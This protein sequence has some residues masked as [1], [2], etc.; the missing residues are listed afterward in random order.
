MKCRHCLA[1]VE[2][3]FLDLGTAPPSNAYLTLEEAR[4]PESWLPLRLLVCDRCWLVQTEDFAGREA[5]F[6]REYAYFSSVSSTWLD[7]A[8]RYVDEMVDRFG[9]TERS[10]VVEVAANDGYLLQYVK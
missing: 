5:L 8:R 1:D 10:Q 7:H 9:L 2:R 4:G 3:V 6:T